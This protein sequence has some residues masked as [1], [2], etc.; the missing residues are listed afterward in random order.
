MENTE[1]K[2]KPEKKIYYYSPEYK[3]EVWGQNTPEFKEYR[4]K[5]LKMYYEKN[6]ER[7]YEYARNKYKTE[8]TYCQCCEKYVAKQNKYHWHS[9]KHLNN[10][11]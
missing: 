1:P 4:R 2:P 6:K 3:N 10:L 8:L 11:L 9:Q 5:Y 7:I